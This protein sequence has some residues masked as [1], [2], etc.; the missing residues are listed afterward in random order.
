MMAI[1]MPGRGVAAVSE[2]SQW[3]D[4]V[5]LSAALSKELSSYQNIQIT[6]SGR[7]FGYD[8]A[9]EKFDIDTGGCYFTETVKTSGEPESRFDFNPT[10]EPWSNG[11]GPFWA[12]VES[13]AYNG[14]YVL[15]VVYK[16]GALG[17]LYNFN[18]AQVFGSLSDDKLFFGTKAL[19]ADHFASLFLEVGD[20]RS[21]PEILI[22]PK[23]QFPNGG[24]WLFVPRCEIVNENGQDLIHVV[25]QDA[26]TNPCEREEIW[27]DPK[28]ALLMTRR[29]RSFDLCVP[30]KKDLPRWE[31]IV[32]EAKE[33]APGF[34]FPA[35]AHLTRY[36][37][38][39]PQEVVETE[40]DKVTLNV[41]DTGDLFNPSLKIGTVVKDNRYGD[42][43]VVGRAGSNLHSIMRTVHPRAGE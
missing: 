20:R 1:L 6:G 35:K 24:S 30:G 26:P 25:F 12:Q 8:Q 13:V 27:L 11:T 36:V 23:V 38:N 34:W 2:V 17:K 9:T 32:D 33:F 15:D 19:L 29:V 43:Y 14:K 31:Y 39:V 41:K 7:R 42:T 22:N 28:R 10:Y 4:P 3:T 40:V 5:Q 18:R 16:H 37:A 21:L